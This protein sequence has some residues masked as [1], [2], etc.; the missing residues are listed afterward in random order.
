MCSHRMPCVCVLPLHAVC[1]CSHY[2]PCVCVCSHCA[3]RGCAQVPLSPF[4]RARPVV[5]FKLGPATA[6]AVLGLHYKDTD[7]SPAGERA[8]PRTATDR[9]R[10]SPSPHSMLSDCVHSSSRALLVLSPVAAMVT[11]MVNCHG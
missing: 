7:L 11:A 6:T 9:R 3:C 10:P 1:V 2:M 4:V 5:V 8:T